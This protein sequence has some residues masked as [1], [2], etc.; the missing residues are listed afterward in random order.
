MIQR[1]KTGVILIAIAA[2]SRLLGAF[3]LPNTFGD[4]YVY[5]RDIGTLSTKIRGGTFGLTDL[6]G[7][8]LPVYQFVAAVANVFVGNGFYA[9]KFVSAIFGIGVCLLV[10]ALVFRVTGHR[11]AALL[12]FVLIAVNPL[13]ILTSTSAL[14]DVPHGFFVLAALYFVLSR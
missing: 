3:F 5:I 4:A 7:F 14:T 9:G 10:Y 6:Y 1:L 13:H 12:S 11:Y 2:I 8:W